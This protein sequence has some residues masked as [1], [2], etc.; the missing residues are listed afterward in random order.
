MKSRLQGEGGPL[1]PPGGP[2]WPHAAVGSPAP[3]RR[4]GGQTSRPAGPG[5]LRGRAGG[6][7]AGSLL[8]PVASPSAGQR[9][10]V[11]EPSWGSG[12]VPG[13]EIGRTGDE[14][15]R[16]RDP[17]PRG[18][19]RFCLGTSSIF[20]ATVHW[21]C[22]VTPLTRV[23]LQPTPAR[24]HQDRRTSGRRFPL[25][26]L[27]LVGL[28]WALAHSCA[29]RETSRLAGPQHRR[30]SAGRGCQAHGAVTWGAGP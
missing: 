22:P 19:R 26:P 30:K 28:G 23:P 14:V 8:G 7:G 11:W 15:W 1:P 29:S 25:R 2:G 10:R 16:S 3:R 4:P 13:V 9:E 18:G 12:S 20:R 17:A 21:P 27:G 24:P 5:A 6:A